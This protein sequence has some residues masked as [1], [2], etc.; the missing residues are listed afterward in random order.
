MVTDKNVKK[1]W[2]PRTSDCFLVTGGQMKRLRDEESFEKRREML[3][4]LRHQRYDGG[5]ETTRKPVKFD[6]LGGEYQV[7]VGGG[8]P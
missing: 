8:E 3:V 4:L 6:N 1:D 5:V 2:E 7:Y